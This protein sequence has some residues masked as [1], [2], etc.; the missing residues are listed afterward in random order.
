MPLA[1]YAR[2]E[3]SKVGILRLDDGAANSFS[4]EM[5]REVYECVAAAE[6][7]LGTC[8]GALVILGNNRV[9]SGGFDLKVM[10]SGPD[11]AKRLVMEGSAIIDK[12]LRFPRPIVVGATGHAVALGTFI[13][14][15]GDYR[16][17]PATVGGKAAKIGLNE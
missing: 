17:G 10:M 8:G 7:D 11:N 15:M 9:L 3:G 14:L 13:L 2:E 6:S 4:H 16:V 12:L 5:C 1:T